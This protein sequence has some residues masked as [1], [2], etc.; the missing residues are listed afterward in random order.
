MQT[1]PIRS[2]LALQGLPLGGVHALRRLQGVSRA[3]FQGH[4]AAQLG[5]LVPF[6]WGRFKG[7]Q[8]HTYFE[9]NLVGGLDFGMEVGD[10][11]LVTLSNPIQA[12]NLGEAE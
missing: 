3:I 5:E 10:G 12:T 4:L 7:N 1:A 2:C 6:F 8:R 9:T 11:F